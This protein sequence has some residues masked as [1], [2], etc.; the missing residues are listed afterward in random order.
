MIIEN[1]RSYIMYIMPH[2]FD[3]LL[4]P[5][6]TVRENWMCAKLRFFGG[7]RKLNARK[8]DARKLNVR[9]N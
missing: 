5:L 4:Y 9:K 2:S 6:L 3:L 1:E 8:L 7:A